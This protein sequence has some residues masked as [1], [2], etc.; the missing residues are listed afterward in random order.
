MKRLFLLRHGKAQP[1]D[2]SV[3]DFERTLLLS[4]M[5]DASAIARYLHKGDYKLDLI[6]C[7]SSARTTQTG[8]L[9][10]QVLES[11]I[12]YRDIFTLPGGP[13]LLAGGRGPR[14]PVPNL[15]LVGHNPGLEHI[16]ALLAREPVRRKERARHEALE[17][18]FPTSHL[19]QLDCAY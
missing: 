1:A 6:L 18:K 2:G 8:E 7:S 3:E 9:V 4:G 10:L 11:E 13:K 16:A 17:E 5:Q 19:A 14:P 12:E 15:M